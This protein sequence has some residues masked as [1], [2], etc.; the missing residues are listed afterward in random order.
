MLRR[1]FGGKREELAEGCRRLQNEEE[2]CEL[3]APLNLIT[4]IKSRRTG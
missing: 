1:M 4:V 3:Y 2:L